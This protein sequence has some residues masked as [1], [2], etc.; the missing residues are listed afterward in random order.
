[1]L[2]TESELWPEAKWF[3]LLE[4]VQ[5]LNMQLDDQGLL[6]DALN[7]ALRQ[8]DIRWITV[9]KVALN[10]ESIES[11]QVHFDLTLSLADSESVVFR[12][13]AV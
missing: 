10:R 13:L 1:M 12:Q 5:S 4:V 2:V 3:G 7:N 6:R 11:G 8:L 9:R